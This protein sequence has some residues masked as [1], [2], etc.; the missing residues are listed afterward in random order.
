MRVAREKA[1]A[2]ISIL[3]RLNVLDKGLRMA[4]TGRDVFAPLSRMLSDDELAMLESELKDFQVTSHEFRRRDRKPRSLIEAIGDQLEPHI[5]AELPRSYDVVGDI[6]VLE[7]PQNLLEHRQIVG[8]AV[9]RVDPHV[10]TVL[11]KA[12]PVSGKY[13]IR[14][15]ILL[16]GRSSTITEHR[17]HGWIFRLDPVRVYFSPRLSHERQRIAA[18]VQP[19]ETLV[20]MFAGVGPFSIVV[21]GVRNVRKVYGVDINPDAVTFML[22]NI[23]L[24]K[25]RGKVTA[26]LADAAAAS[27]F[28]L[29]MAD[30]VIMNLP[31]D[32]D[33]FIPQACR[34]LS[35]GGGVIHFYTF[36]SEESPREAV[37]ENVRRSVECAGRRVVRVEAVKDVRPVAPR[38]WQLAI[39]IRVA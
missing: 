10:K 35:E 37:L 8:E 14:D 36:T 39:D 12:S 17:E 32:S 26:V 29:G 21:A 15:F 28:L 2:A 18:E 4:S 16:A 25:L 3:K 20:D 30:R 7:L 31:A 34:L 9:M 27:E 5:L 38:E 33:R 13:R 22:Q 19:G 24:N 11:A 6:A 1:E 23:T